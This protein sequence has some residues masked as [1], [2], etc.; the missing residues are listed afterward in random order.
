MFGLTPFFMHTSVKLIIK[1]NLA[2]LGF[3]MAATS[4]KK[5]KRS[6]NRYAFDQFFF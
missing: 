1:K 3:L 2:I 6:K 4:Q 5:T